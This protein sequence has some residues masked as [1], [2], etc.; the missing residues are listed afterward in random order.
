MHLFD[1]N[2]VRTLLVS[3]N[4]FVETIFFPDFVMNKK[5]IFTVTFDQL[6]ALIKALISL[7]NLFYLP[8]T[9]KW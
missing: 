3:N 9:F 5:S 1:Q 7:I 2:T 4:I 8:Q 6:T